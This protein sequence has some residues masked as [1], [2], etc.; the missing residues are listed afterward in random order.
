MSNRRYKRPESVL[1]VVVDGAGEVLLLRRR[2]P[3][4]FIQSVT[5]SL[6]WGESARQAALR[7]LR[8]ET[9]IQA[10]MALQDLSHCVEFP[11]KLPWRERYA[12]GTWVNREHWFLLRLPCRRSIRLSPMEHTAYYWS[13]WPRAARM[14]SSRTNR[15]AILGLFM[16]GMAGCERAVGAE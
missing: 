9:G 10:G 11:I 6:R 4:D 5:G 8:E 3:A 15:D 7:E 14:A 12:P 13:A 2:R 16:K 1:V